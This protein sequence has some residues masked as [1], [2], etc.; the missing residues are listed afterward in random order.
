[1]LNQLA[2]FAVRVLR[3]RYRDQI[4]ELRALRQ[5][6]RPGDVVCDVGANKGSYLYWL[7]R[8]C[9]TGRL[10]AFEPQPSLAIRLSEICAAL[11]L[12]NVVVE[13]KAVYSMSGE[14]ELFVPDGHQPGASLL[15]PSGKFTAIRVPTITLDHYFDE[16][17]RISAIKIDVEGAELHVL[18]GAERILRRHRPL[19]VVEC[20]DR[21]HSPDGSI[22][23]VFS[24][25]TALGYRGS[26]INGNQVL[27]IERFDVAVHQRRE[28]EWFWKE[29]GYC[30]NFIFEA[31]TQPGELA[32]L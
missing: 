8:W 24:Y 23:E 32:T 16:D 11:R 4:I 18:K 31:V 1:M 12:R 7:A 28:G 13:S 17:I 6:I 20:E 15:I 27:P 21:H 3:A 2:R 19:I 10:F 26:F 25:L 22:D 9:E 30:H 14:L 5:H 29:P